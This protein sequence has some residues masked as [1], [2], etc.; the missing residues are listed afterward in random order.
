LVKNNEVTYDITRDIKIFV[1][2]VEATLYDFRVGNSVTLT[3]ESSAVVKIESVTSTITEGNVSGTVTTVDPSSKHISVRTADGTGNIYEEK[4]Y[5]SDS[6]TTLISADGST[7]MFRD[8]KK[9]SVVNAYGEY[10]NG[11][12]EA[13]S[14][15][16]VK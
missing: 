2:G 3:T 12:F 1:N 10:N 13:K 14:I 8:I 4:V 5:C 7:K 15:V 9:G 16:I 6:K 11:R